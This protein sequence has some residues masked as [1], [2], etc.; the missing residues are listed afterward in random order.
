MRITKEQVEQIF[1]TRTHQAEIVVDLYRLVYP[2]FD[3]IAKVDGFPAAGK[4]L[5]R[6]IWKLA[7]EFDRKHH[8]DVMTGG[9]WLNHGFSTNDKLE[10]WEVDIS[11]VNIIKEAEAQGG[12][13]PEGAF[14]VFK[15]KEINP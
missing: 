5:S 2:D 11:H 7:M 10:P 3:R 14:A 15:G 6:L 1:A 4:E 13:H 9:C 12:D 8:P